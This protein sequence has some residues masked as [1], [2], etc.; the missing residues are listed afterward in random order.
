MS[1]LGAA[2]LPKF[3]G[4]HPFIITLNGQGTATGTTDARQSNLVSSKGATSAV[5][6][7]KYTTGTATPGASA[8]N[9]FLIRS[10]GSI[11]SDN[12][13]TGDASIAVNNSPA[14]GNLNITEMGSATYYGIFPTD[15]VT[16]H[17]SPTFGIAVQNNSGD[18]SDSNANNFKLEYTLVY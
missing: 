17:L 14:M 12:A 16:P 6:G 10:D 9:L 3:D 18:V 7:I 1:N 11:A 13:G 2:I 4:P 5:I 8:V 15:A